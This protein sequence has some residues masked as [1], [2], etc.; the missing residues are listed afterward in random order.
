MVSRHEADCK[1]DDLPSA[2]GPSIE[3]QRRILQKFEVAEEKARQ[4]RVHNPELCGLEP[5]LSCPD[6]LAGF[7]SEPPITSA[8][9]LAYDAKLR[10][11]QR[12]EAERL[13][14]EEQRHMQAERIRCLVQAIRPALIEVVRDVLAEDLPEAVRLI[15]SEEATRAS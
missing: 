9:L 3:E 14:L 1:E 15:L 8:E 4:P 11:R 2:I 10:E 12:D 7:L 13:L 5:E 6:C